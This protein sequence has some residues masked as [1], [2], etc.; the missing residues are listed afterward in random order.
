MTLALALLKSFWKP[1]LVIAIVVYSLFQVYE[2]GEDS[3]DKEW[4]DKWNAEQL[5]LTEE[6][7]AA[8]TKARERESY[9][10]SEL[11]KVS[12]DVQITIDQIK[13][14]AG[15]A[16]VAANSLR[17]AAEQVAKRASKAC[18]NSTVASERETA[19][20]G[21][22]V[23]ADVFGSCGERLRQMAEA[24]DRSYSS[25]IACERSY[26]TVRF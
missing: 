3:K 24:A 19:S 25:G 14:N 1:L 22:M 20:A 16:V 7:A 11:D 18:A 15:V 23:L 9:W 4:K 8:E 21:V 17:S 13:T 12:R 6:R 26:E 5:R 2:A 10:V